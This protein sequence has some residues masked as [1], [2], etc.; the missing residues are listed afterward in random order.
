LMV[1]RDVGAIARRLGWS[2][3]ETQLWRLRNAGFINPAYE[4]MPWLG[5]RLFGAEMPCLRCKNSEFD[6]T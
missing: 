4:V 2:F 1:A 5:M 3:A 6:L